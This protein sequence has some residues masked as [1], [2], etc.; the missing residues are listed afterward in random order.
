LQSRI[1]GLVEKVDNDRIG[2]AGHS[3]GSYTAEAVAGALVDLPGRAAATFTDS[4][5]KAILC[6]SPQGPG[7]FGLT[8][9]SL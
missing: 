7:Q 6:L 9:H 1:P 4:R 5:A 3:M 8:A 2:V